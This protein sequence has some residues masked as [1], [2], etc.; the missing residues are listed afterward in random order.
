VD[1]ILKYK[2][3]MPEI[4][5]GVY[6]APGAWIIGK[7]KIEEEASIW[8]NTVLRGDVNY[9][10][11]GKKT[12]IQDNCVVHVETDGCSTIIGD[13]VTIGHN[14]VIHACTI[15]DRCLIG[16]GATLLDG[17]F[18]GEGSIVGANTLISKGKK[19]PKRSLILGSPG[20]VIREVTDEE[21]EMILISA[22][23]Y[24]ALA[25]SYLAT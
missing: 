9:I 10:K 1:A 4:S 12:N 11:V 7:V 5:K 19:Y 18:I 2:N 21:Y 23:R 8:F 13:E 17:S 20:K 24:V 16:M 14:A 3:I 6:V 25:G 22:S 15:E